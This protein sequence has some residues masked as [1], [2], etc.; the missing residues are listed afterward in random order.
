MTLNFFFVSS[1]IYH[2]T[3]IKQIVWKHIIEGCKNVVV[4]KNR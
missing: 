1:Q 3:T 4:I 2:N